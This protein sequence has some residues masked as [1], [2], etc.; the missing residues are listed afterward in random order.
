MIITDKSQIST[1]ATIPTAQSAPSKHAWE[2]SVKIIQSLTKQIFYSWVIQGPHGFRWKPTKTQTAWLVV[3]FQAQSAVQK[4][5]QGKF[6]CLLHWHLPWIPGL[7]W[8]RMLKNL[9]WFVVVLI[10]VRY[11]LLQYNLMHFP[12][13]L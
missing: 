4:I 1:P 3:I 7:T 13:I 12:I 6:H 10:L 5:T 8:T 11:R 9:N 2:M